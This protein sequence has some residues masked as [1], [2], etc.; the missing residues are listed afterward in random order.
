MSKKSLK[1]IK[2]SYE[3][4]LTIY[5]YGFDNISA[6]ILIPLL[7][8]PLFLIDYISIFKED[9]RRYKWNRDKY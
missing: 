2:K 8:S 4:R 3:N 7:V 9:Y 6:I 1:N 5:L